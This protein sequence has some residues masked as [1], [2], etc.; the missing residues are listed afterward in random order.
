MRASLLCAVDRTEI[1]WNSIRHQPPFPRHSDPL[2]LLQLF[3]HTAKGS[4]PRPRRNRS[5]LPQRRA[6]ESYDGNTRA[7]RCQI[8][9]HHGELESIL[10]LL[11]LSLLW[12]GNGEFDSQCLL[13]SNWL[14][15]PHRHT[16]PYGWEGADATHVH[17]V[18][19]R[20]SDSAFAAEYDWWRFALG[21]ELWFY[22][23]RCGGL[24]GECRCDGGLFDEKAVDYE[25]LSN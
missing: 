17:F 19:A 1:H 20:A 25:N 15:C 10:S 16:I 2:I 23:G 3:P 13:W 24:W 5:C 6:A 9:P 21:F 18:S 8:I 12:Q 7:G 22:H 14:W 4:S 11:R